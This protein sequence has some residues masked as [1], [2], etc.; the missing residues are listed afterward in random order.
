[1]N[2]YTESPVVAEWKTPVCDMGTNTHR[3][4]LLRLTVSADNVQG[5]SLQFGYETR[6]NALTRM[7]KGIQTFALEPLDFAN[8]T[9]DLPFASS[10]TVRARERGFNYIQFYFRSE[11]NT[12]CIVNNMTATYRI[13]AENRGVR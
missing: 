2:I 3:K 5:G 4:T 10:Y 12:N 13:I 1:M 11:S 8:F 7:D 6:Q 9:L